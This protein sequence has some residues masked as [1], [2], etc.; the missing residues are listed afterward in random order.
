MKRVMTWIL[1]WALIVPPA[2]LDAGEGYLEQNTG[3]TVLLSELGLTE[4]EINR[5]PDHRIDLNRNVNVVGG[6]PA[7]VTLAANS[8]EMV[9]LQ[10]NAT[11]AMGLWEQLPGARL[12]FSVGVF[13]T[14]AA[15]FVRDS[16]N[17]VTLAGG[18]YNL[19]GQGG[20]HLAPGDFG[21]P[22]IIEFDMTLRR[23]LNNGNVASAQAVLVQEI[24]HGIGFN[25]SWLVDNS[26][27]NLTGASSP[28]S[29]MSYSA[30]RTTAID[31]GALNPDDVSLA[32]RLYYNPFS[33]QSATTGT[34]CGRALDA[35]GA[36]DLYGANVL[37]VNR[38]SGQAVVSRVSGYATSKPLGTSDGRFSLDG[39]PPGDYDVL[40]SSLDD[41]AVPNAN[42]SIDHM[43]LNEDGTT[44]WVSAT[45]SFATGFVRAWVRNV[46]LR[47]GEVVDVGYVL[48][49]VDR[50]FDQPSRMDLLA[51]YTGATSY[52]HYWYDY[53]SDAPWQMAH[54]S[55]SQTSS[56]YSARL[57][58]GRYAVRI[59]GW[60]GTSWVTVQN[61]TWRDY[62][63]RRASMT[64]NRATRGVDVGIAVLPT[65]A[66]SYGINL[67]EGTS[68]V[69]GSNAFHGNRYTTH[70]PS[71]AYQF[72]IHAH[73]N[74]SVNSFVHVG[75]SDLLVP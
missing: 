48:A 52:T 38:A 2:G 73:W 35:A 54:R 59:F 68:A 8:P 42:A 26:V 6:N 70:L 60:N 46:P 50:N 69:A 41:A 36:A 55:G 58:P 14:A 11:F 13:R 74:T 40:V 53:W 33:P 67:R 61:W 65:E 17:L 49:G 64:W 56:S 28:P 62:G 63:A 15:Q 23:S 1:V 75:W 29:L 47:A 66:Y 20:G 32:C 10:Q 12:Q 18:T 7:W 21:I 45:G 9:Q 43:Q 25:H 27:L 57:A 72:R 51:R 24:G 16:A 37:L 31:A 22:E 30:N 4:D 5:F 39:V 44:G 34:V 19:S 71:G 3:V